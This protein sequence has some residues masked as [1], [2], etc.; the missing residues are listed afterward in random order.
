MTWF[1]PQMQSRLTSRLKGMIFSDRPVK[2]PTRDESQAELISAGPSSDGADPAHR[3]SFSRNSTDFDDA[4]DSGHQVVDTGQ[5][6]VKYSTS[7]HVT[8]ISPKNRKKKTDKQ[9]KKHTGS[10]MKKRDPPGHK[11][12]PEH[13]RRQELMRGHKHDSTQQVYVSVGG[14]SAVEPIK[15]YIH[16]TNNTPVRQLSVNQ[17]DVDDE[18]RV[19]LNVGGIRHETHIATLRNVPDSRLSRLA[20]IHMSSSGRGKQEYFFDRHPSVFNSIIDFYR[21][22]RLFFSQI[23]FSTHFFFTS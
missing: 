2:S 15:H 13:R 9:T 1:C 11:I 19:M 23:F 7:G 3:P 12:T 8:I 20:D 22:G 14:A 16:S 21:T 6:V 10:I 18:E 5:Q 4:A 17:Y